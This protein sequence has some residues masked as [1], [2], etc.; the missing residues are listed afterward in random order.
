MARP[1][2]RYE[3]PP[4][5]DLRRY[6]GAYG[7]DAAGWYLNLL[8]RSHIAG[9]AGQAITTLLRRS[10]LVRRSA[11]NEI[12]KFLGEELPADVVEMLS[13]RKPESGIKSLRADEF[14]FF[15]QQLPEEIRKFGRDFVPGVTPSSKAP[16]GFVGPLDRLFERRRLSHFARIDLSLPDRVLLQDLAEFLSEKRRELAAV[17]VPQPYRAALRELR[18]KKRPPLKTWANLAVL[19]YLDVEHWRHES[20]ASISREKMSELLGIGPD[21]LRETAKYAYLLQHPFVLRGWL[22]LFAR[23]AI[24]K[25]AA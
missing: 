20:G 14:Y 12:L 24:E 1:R 5:F 19:P 22:H 23:A 10:P 4:W 15:E 8:L 21:A 3:P 6:D 17:Q 9:S 7:M 2:K 16:A 11:S 13:G 25:R 18:A